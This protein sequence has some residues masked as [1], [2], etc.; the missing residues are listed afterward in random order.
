MVKAHFKA[1]FKEALN[2]CNFVN[3]IWWSNICNSYSIS[4]NA[5]NLSLQRIKQQLVVLL[6]YGKAKVYLK[7][8]LLKVSSETST[9]VY[10]S[11]SAKVFI[12]ESIQQLTGCPKKIAQV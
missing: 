1:Y 9:K 5:T 3:Y 11:K 2:I 6:S 4:N 8:V 10:I 12:L 7:A